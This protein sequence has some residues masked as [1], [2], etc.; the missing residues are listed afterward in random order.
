M[1]KIRQMDKCF[2]VSF[3]NSS[4]TAVAILISLARI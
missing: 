1:G 2:I 3:G 4:I